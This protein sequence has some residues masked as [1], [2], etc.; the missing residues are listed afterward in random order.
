MTVFS[1]LGGA[2]LDGD[3]PDAPFGAV[4]LSGAP[5]RP[6]LDQIAGRADLDPYALAVDDGV[7]RLSRGDLLDEIAALAAVIVNG[8]PPGAPVGV[9]LQHGASAVVA[10]LACLPAA[11]R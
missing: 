1:V 7:R 5:E 9:R 2:P 6:L 4:D 3:G 11:W 8:V 10:W